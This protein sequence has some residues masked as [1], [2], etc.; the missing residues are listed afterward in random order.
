MNQYE[1][2]QI[3]RFQQQIQIEPVALGESGFVLHFRCPGQD[4]VAR[5]HATVCGK[6]VPWYQTD[7][8]WSLWANAPIAC[9]DCNLALDCPF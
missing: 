4:E 5:E 8:D 6:K 7:G 2:K 9:P 1:Y 3:V